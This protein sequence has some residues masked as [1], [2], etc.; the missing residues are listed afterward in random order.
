MATYSDVFDEVGMENLKIAE[1][2]WR[3]ATHYSSEETIEWLGENARTAE[4]ITVGHVIRMGGEE[5]V[6]AHEITDAGKA[7]G[8]SVIPRSLVSRIIYLE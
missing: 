8:T 5:I 1:I 3:D 6:V 4:F 7:R 2:Y